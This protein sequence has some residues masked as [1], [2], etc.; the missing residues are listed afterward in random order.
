MYGRMLSVTHVLAPRYL[1][2]IAPT[3]NANQV[4]KWMGIAWFGIYIC[5][6]PENGACA[7]R[8][9]EQGQPH[10]SLTIL[11]AFAS[12]VCLRLEVRHTPCTLG[13]SL[14]P[15]RLVAGRASMEPRGSWL[16]RADTAG[17]CARAAPLPCLGARHTAPSH[18]PPT[19]TLSPI[20][21]EV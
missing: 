18:T 20:S 15:R 4:N 8:A 14:P 13:T 19:S 21:F 11:Y 1:N 10:A 12:C 16:R 17:G 3:P 9:A 6:R 5:A 2:F 7:Q